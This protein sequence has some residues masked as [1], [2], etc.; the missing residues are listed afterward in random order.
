MDD[1]V[2]DLIDLKASEVR[3]RSIVFKEGSNTGRYQCGYY[4]GL[5]G[6]Q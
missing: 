1:E 6:L 2:M 5:L 4:I 3:S